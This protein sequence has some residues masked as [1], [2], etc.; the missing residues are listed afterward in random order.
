MFKNK[1]YLIVNDKET[2]GCCI[3]NTFNEK[4]VVLEDSYIVLN[5]NSKVNIELLLEKEQYEKEKIFNNAIIEKQFELTNTTKIDESYKYE[6]A[7]D[8]KIKNDKEQ[9]KLRNRHFRK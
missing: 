2:T 5:I 1:I 4:N 7:L 6:N 3:I 8:I 9:Q